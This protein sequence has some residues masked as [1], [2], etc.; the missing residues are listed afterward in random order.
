MKSRFVTA[1]DAVTA[2]TTSSAIDIKY[3][4]RV[5]LMLTRADDNTGVST[6]TV[7]GSLDN[8]TFIDLNLITNAATTNAQTIT[9]AASVA[10]TNENASVL[11]ALDLEFGGYKYIKVKVTETTNG[12]HSAVLVIEE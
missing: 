11:A 2:T 6:F 3:A 1:L 5:T 10:I 8:V 12:T 9:R 7:T 4:K